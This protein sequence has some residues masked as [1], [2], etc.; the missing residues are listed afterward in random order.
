M[1][2]DHVPGGRRRGAAAGA[3]GRRDPRR[4]DADPRVRLGHHVGQRAHGHEPQPVGAGPHLGR[5]ERRL[6]GRARD[7]PGDARARQRHRRLDPRARRRSAAPSAS[8]PPTAASAPARIWPLARTLDHPGPMARTPADAALLLEVIAGP[9]PPTRPRSTCRSA[10]STRRSRAASRASSV[11]LCPDLHLVPLAPG[12]QRGVRRRAGGRARVRR[13]RSRGRA[14]RGARRSADVS[15]S[16]SAPRPCTPTSRRASIPAR[17]AEY[18]ADV[19]GRLEPAAAR[20]R[21]ATTCAPPPSASGSAPR[22]AG[23]SREVDLL[24]TPVGAGTAVPIGASARAPRRAR[25]TS[26]TSSCRYT[27]PQDLVGLP[28]CAFRAGFDELGIPVGVQFTGAEWDD[29]R[30]LGAAHAVFEATPEVQERWPARLRRS[31]NPRREEGTMLWKGRYRCAVTLSVDFDAETLWSGTF[32]LPDAEPAVARRLRHPRRHAAHPAPARGPRHP[33]DVHGAG[34][35]HR[36]PPGRV[37]RHQGVRRRGRPPRLLPRERAR[38]A[39]RRGARAH[40]ARHRPHRGGVRHAPEGQPLAAVRARAEH[41]RPARGERLRLRLEPVR[42]RR[43]VPPARARHRRPAARP[44]RAA[45][46]LGARRRAVL[47]VQLLP[48]H[49]G[50]LDALAGARD[51]EGGVRRLVPGG[52][53]LPA[54]RP[55]VLHRA[56]SAHRAD[57]RP[58]HVHQELP[59]RVDRDAPRGRRGVALACRRRRACGRPAARRPRR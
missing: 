31:R 21:R 17:A 24:L 59:G 41:R 44:G 52:R 12:V 5:L 22:S 16:R 55:P 33:R 32:K 9:T 27:T 47:P 11:G 6:G 28:A 2:R 19:R 34:P 38:A 39:G 15:A 50:A 29:A 49:V 13:A 53:L 40:A 43:A 20:G 1:F 48:V 51:L 56:P 23:C 36:R 42:A 37:P 58:L 54:R 35:G 57:R 8:S 46:H 4:Q 45:R 26:A 30:V 7:A 18:G 25:S 10:T 14:A 3:R